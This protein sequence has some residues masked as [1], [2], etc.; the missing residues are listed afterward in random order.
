MKTIKNTTNNNN[1]IM[2]YFYLSIATIIL[3]VGVYFFKFPNNFSF[4]GISGLAIILSDVTTL[5][6]GVLTSIINI[7][8][9]LVGFIFIGKSFGI[10]TVYITILMSAGLYL[11]ELF[12]PLSKPLTTQPILDLFF[13]IAL[14]SL[15]SAIM[16]NLQ[17]SSGG[18]DIIAMILKKYTSINIGLAL[19]FVDLFIIISAFFVFG[20]E[21]G[22]YSFFGL[23]AKS[24]LVDDFIENINRCKYFTIICSKPDEICHF[25]HTELNR[26]AT[27]F[28]GEGSY[29]H[30]EKYI[31]LTVM[32]RNQAIQLRAFIKNNDE[33]SFM[34]ITNSSEIIG[35]GFRGFN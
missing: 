11:L 22:L 24:I 10:K 31:I 23:V 20:L 9:L 16:F 3:V 17:A 18:T 6:A 29:L 1:K 5:S 28:K 4:G 2:E 34:M 30:Q 14:P 26:S 35:K 33:N 12:V 27:V 8:L 19:F 32:K 7:G 25:I 15:S 13:A 21:T